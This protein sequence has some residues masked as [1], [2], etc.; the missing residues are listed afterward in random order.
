MPGL[1]RSAYPLFYSLCLACFRKTPEILANDTPERVLSPSISSTTAAILSSYP[2]FSIALLRNSSITN[3]RDSFLNYN[4]VWIFFWGCGTHPSLH[5]FSKSDVLRR[6]EKRVLE[7]RV[8][9]VRNTV[10]NRILD[11]HKY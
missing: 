11:I 8:G 9:W 1:S 4:H 5:L 2:P 3:M 6:R 7:N 10:K